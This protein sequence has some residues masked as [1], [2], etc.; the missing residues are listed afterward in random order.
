MHYKHNMSY[1]ERKS[2]VCM[3][4]QTWGVL[5]IVVSSKRCEMK[6]K[7]ILHIDTHT[8]CT[9]Q[10]SQLYLKLATAAAIHLIVHADERACRTH[11]ARIHM[12]CVRLK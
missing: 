5:G 11:I 2:Y 7:E 12:A 8:H 3:S 1:F 6:N 10:T 9:K 4:I